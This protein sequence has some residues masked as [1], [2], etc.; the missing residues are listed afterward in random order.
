MNFSDESIASPDF[1][2]DIVRCIHI[3]LLCV[4]DFA[5]DR[6]G[7]HTVVSMLSRE[8]ARLPSPKQ[9]LFA[10]KWS[11]VAA[12]VGYSSMNELT[13]TILEGR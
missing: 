4:Q 11:G 3:A 12:E 2:E 1:E 8:I 6:P 13:L 9:P 5:E 7:I 10:E